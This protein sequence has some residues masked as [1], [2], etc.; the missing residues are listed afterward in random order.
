MVAA[1]RQTDD[2]QASTNLQRIDDLEI[3]RKS[4]E[5]KE[6]DEKIRNAIHESVPL[7]GE[8]SKLVLSFLDKDKEIKCEIKNLIR[9][10]D[11]ESLWRMAKRFCTLVGWIISLFMAGFVGHFFR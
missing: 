6:L 9:E 11:K 10:A 3:F 2:L 7:Q 4:F 8:I 1:T 5:G